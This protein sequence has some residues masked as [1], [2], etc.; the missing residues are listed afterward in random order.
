MKRPKPRSTVSEIS[1]K[2]YE[3]RESSSAAYSK[4]VARLHAREDFDL[5][6]E[7]REWLAE[8]TSAINNKQP[9]DPTTHKR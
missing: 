4:D 3:H 2:I 1:R 9:Q 5:I 7:I 8:Q 6:N